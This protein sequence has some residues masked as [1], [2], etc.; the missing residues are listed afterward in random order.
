MS[1]DFLEGLLRADQV[2]PGLDTLDRLPLPLESS[3]GTR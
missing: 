2:E 1:F 3:L